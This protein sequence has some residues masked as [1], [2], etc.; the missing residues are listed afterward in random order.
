[1]FFVPKSTEC[2]RDVKLIP[3]TQKKVM[4]FASDLPSDCVHPVVKE[5]HISVRITLGNHIRLSSK[6]W[7]QSFLCISRL[8]PTCDI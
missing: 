6:S 3:Y 1:M 7:T 4:F 8:P 5:G 2:Y